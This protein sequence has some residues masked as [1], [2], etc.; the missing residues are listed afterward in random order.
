MLMW[1]VL[2]T[3]GCH[4]VVAGLRGVQEPHPHVLRPRHLSRQ[5][6]SIRPHI[7][8]SSNSSI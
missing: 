5:R 6:H 7:C 1:M 4:V 8:V 2:D 3:G